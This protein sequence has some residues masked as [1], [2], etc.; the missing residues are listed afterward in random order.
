MSF[1]LIFVLIL[2]S[3]VVCILFLISFDEREPLVL[4]QIFVQ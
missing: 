3:A 4:V 1:C 2:I